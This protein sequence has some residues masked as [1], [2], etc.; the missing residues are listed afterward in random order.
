MGKGDAGEAGKGAER[1]GRMDRVKA[2]ERSRRCGDIDEIVKGWEMR[3]E[4]CPDAGVVGKR[5]RGVLND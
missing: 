3:R 4:E 1:R 2:W 5:R